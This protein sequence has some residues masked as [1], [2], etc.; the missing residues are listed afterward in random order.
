[1]RTRLAT[2]IMQEDAKAICQLPGILSG[3]QPL[4]KDAIGGKLPTART[5]TYDMS[6]FIQE[7]IGNY[8]NLANISIDSIRPAPTPFLDESVEFEQKNKDQYQNPRKEASDKEKTP[9]LASVALKSLMKI[10]YAARMCRYDLLRATCVLA[11][12]ISNWDYDCDRRLYRLIQYLKYS[13]SF[14]NTGFCGDDFKNCKIALFA[15]ADFAGCNKTANSTTGNYLAIVGPNTHMP[16]AAI[17]KK[18]SCF[19]KHM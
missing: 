17:S 7:C 16:L 4:P 3:G 14:V 15:D 8:A 12:R 1:M 2:S 19:L 13:Q 6:E 5:I 18:Q 9:K 11:R 10:L